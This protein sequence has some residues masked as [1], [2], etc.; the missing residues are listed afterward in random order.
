MKDKK[1]KEELHK[2]IDSIEDE[3]TLN[4]LK[5][6]MVAYTTSSTTDILDELSP[7]Q[8]AALMQS[9]KEDDNGESIDYNKS[10]KAFDEWRKKL[11]SAGDSNQ[12]EIKHTD[13]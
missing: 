11:K 7:A 9:I 6:D 2:L 5:E 13:I 3:E 10:K 8:L 1:I 4:I 12:N